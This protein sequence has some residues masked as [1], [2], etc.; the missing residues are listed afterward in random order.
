M[1]MMNAVGQLGLGAGIFNGM[2]VLGQDN[3]FQYPWGEFDD[4]TQS[5]QFT[6]N[7]ELTQ[8]DMP[9]IGVDGVLGAET[10]GAQR[11]IVENLPY[12]AAAHQQVLD[13]ADCRSFAYPPTAGGGAA[14]ATVRTPPS[15]AKTARA[16]MGTLGWLL[17]AAGVAAAGVYL[18]TRKK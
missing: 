8:A 18:A 3:G 13:V 12:S 1:H 10:C 15:T 7:V 4:G 6:T 11:W 2:G 5:V 14:A 9:N 16:G 17:I